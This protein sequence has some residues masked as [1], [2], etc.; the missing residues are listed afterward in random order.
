MNEICQFEHGWTYRVLG[1]EVSQTEK[2]K[3]PYDFTYM[4]NAENNSN[5]ETRKKKSYRHREQQ[6]LLERWAVGR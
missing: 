6:L 5:E 2:D 3:H 1:Y 4:W